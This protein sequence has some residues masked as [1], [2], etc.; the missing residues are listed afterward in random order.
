MQ[1][2]YGVIFVGMTRNPG[3]GMEEITAFTT[4]TY[5]NARACAH[6]HTHTHTHT[7]NTAEEQKEIKH[8]QHS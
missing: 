7:Q 8:H 6:T 2:S 4:H 3:A 1:L 5:T